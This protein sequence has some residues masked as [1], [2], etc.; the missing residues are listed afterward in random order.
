MTIKWLLDILTIPW[1]RKLHGPMA[2][3]FSGRFT[4]GDLDSNDY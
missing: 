3:I 4:L 2:L 1:W